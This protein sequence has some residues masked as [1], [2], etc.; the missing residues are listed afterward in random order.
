MVTR[1]DAALGVF[2]GDIGIVLPRARGGI[3]LRVLLP[4][5]ARLRSV[6]VS[7]LAHV[8]TA[9]AMTVH[10]SQGSEFEHTVLVLPAQ[11][12]RVLTR[13]LVYTGITR[14]RQAFTLVSG[15]RQACWPMPWAASPGAPAGSPAVAPPPPVAV[16][17]PPLALPTHAAAPRVLASV[18]VRTAAPPPA[19]GPPVHA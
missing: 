13:E 14:A 2:N 3:G 8:E 18:A 1:N 7:R 11:S 4:A 9:F 15:R 10:K 19:R 17:L 16:A 6:G 5:R 12:G